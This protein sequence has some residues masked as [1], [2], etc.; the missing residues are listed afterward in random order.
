VQVLTIKP[1]FV[2]TPMTAAFPK[3]PLWATPEKVAVDIEKAIEK[4]RDVLYTPGFWWLIM[5]VITAVPE[6]IFK[7][8]S[9]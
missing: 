5:S 4:K 2:D 6:T 9:L 7:K 3:G 8:L 1:G